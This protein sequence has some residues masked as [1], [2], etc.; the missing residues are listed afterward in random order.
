MDTRVYLHTSSCDERVETGGAFLPLEQDK[1]YVCLLWPFFTQTN[2][3]SLGQTCTGT[4]GY[5]KLE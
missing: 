2:L 5:I 1:A 3:L 4:L